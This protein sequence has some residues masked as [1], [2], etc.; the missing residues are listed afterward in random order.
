MVLADSVDTTRLFV[1]SLITGWGLLAIAVGSIIWTNFGGVAD[2]SARHLARAVRGLEAAR[3]RDTV[4]A[5]R[6]HGGF[7]MALGAGAVLCGMLA[8]LWAVT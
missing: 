6:R 4:R 7:W 8:F 2:F 1:A 5:Y 3:R